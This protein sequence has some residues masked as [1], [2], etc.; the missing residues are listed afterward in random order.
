MKE[1]GRIN[2]AHPI[3]PFAFSSF[4]LHPSEILHPFEVVDMWGPARQNGVEIRG[5][6][7]S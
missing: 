4:I 7:G 3:Q 6:P 5:R 1:I 2:R